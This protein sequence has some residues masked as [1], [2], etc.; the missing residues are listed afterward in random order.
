MRWKRGSVESWQATGKPSTIPRWGTR[1]P[2]LSQKNEFA[3][4]LNAEREEQTA[5]AKARRRHSL[6]PTPRPQRPTGG[7][8][9][10]LLRR[11]GRRSRSGGR[12][13]ASTRRRPDSRT[14]P[15]PP[16]RYGG[17]L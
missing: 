7:P 12:S 4:A 14:R 1:F 13:G 11:G 10:G 15:K 8:S 5:L 16:R 9:K 3:Q 6:R 2:G 17:G